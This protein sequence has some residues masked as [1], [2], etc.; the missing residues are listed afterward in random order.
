MK[1]FRLASGEYPQN[2]GKNIQLSHFKNL[3]DEE[4]WGKFKSGD[5]N[6]LAFIYKEHIHSLFNFGNHQFKDRELVK[7]YIQDIFIEL[8]TKRKKLSSVK[9]IKA[10]LYKSLYNK[11]KQRL[12]QRNKLH[13]NFSAVSDDF[14]IEIP[15]D[16]TI[17]DNE[18]VIDRIKWLN[19]NLQKLNSR[20]R[21]AILLYYYEGFTYEEISEVLGVKSSDGVR[22]LIKRGLDKMKE[23]AKGNDYLFSSSILTLILLG[24]M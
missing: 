9:S 24:M 14:S 12:R 2:E 17:I 13:L 5:D 19:K 22:M 23:E 1:I 7:D 16:K 10:Y 3:S 15:V 8:K 6:A 11:L 18:L 21:Q 20:Q 4:I